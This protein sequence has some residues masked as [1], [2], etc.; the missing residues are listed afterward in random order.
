MVARGAAASA[1][2]AG[3]LPSAAAPPVAPRG[4][5]A[6]LLSLPGDVLAV[7]LSFLEVADLFAV[8]TCNRS[9]RGVC[10][11]HGELHSGARVLS[12]EDVVAACR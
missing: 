9:L 2:M 8:A 11:V 12:V 1:L 10:T 5:G 3:L 6:P 4:G 7:L